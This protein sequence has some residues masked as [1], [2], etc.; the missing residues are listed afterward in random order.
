MLFGLFWVGVL[1]YFMALALTSRQKLL[2]WAAT[3]TVIF[4][5]IA[6][7]SSTPLASMLVV[8]ILLPL[9]KYRQKG[10]QVLWLLFGL[11]V[12]LHFV[13]NG[14]IWGLLARIDLVAGST[15]WYR[16]L[17][18]DYAIKNFEQWALL[19]VKSTENWIVPSYRALTDVCNQYVLEGVRGGIATLLLFV[20]VLCKAVK[21]TW[22][23]SMSISKQQN[24][25]AWSTCVAILGHCT[26]FWAMAYSGQIIMLLY[27][28]FAIVGTMQEMQDSKVGIQHH[29]VY[30]N[31]SSEM[32]QVQPNI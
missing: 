4:A 18:V 25:L 6:T 32:P 12:V 5:V 19:G 21:I 17:L 10:K 20:F 23:S 30:T 1:P 26:A 22:Q 15:G 27:L 7:A 28:T 13:M 3:S 8:I 16:Y 24:W 29:L 2:Y 14:P 31:K 9:F 11:A